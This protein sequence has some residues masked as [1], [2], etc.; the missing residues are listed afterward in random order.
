[1][2]QRT[3]ALNS[4]RLRTLLLGLSYPHQASYYDDWRNA[5]ETSPYFD[6]T[7]QNILNLRP[8]QLERQLSDYDAVVLLH[9]CSSDTLDYLTPLAPALAAR[10]RA[11]LF[12]FIGNEYNSPYVSMAKRIAF[13]REARADF[14]AT[15]LLLEAGDFLYKPAGCRVVSVPHALNPAAFQPGPA[16]ALR[17]VDIGFK[18]FRYPPYLGDDDRNHMLQAV[19]NCTRRFNLKTDISEDVR[20]NREDWAMFLG[21]CRA[22]ISTETGSWYLE[23]GDALMDEIHAYLRAKDRGL[24]L[25]SGGRLR[26]LA[27]RLPTSVKSV[28][29]K[30]LKKGPVKFEMFEDFNTSF[31]ELNERFFKNR[32]RTTVYSKA[33]SSRHFDAIGK[34]TCQIMLEGRYNDILVAGE[35]YIPVKADFSNIADAMRQ[36]QDQSL[37]EA[38]TKATYDYVMASHTYTHRA[39]QVHSLLTAT[40]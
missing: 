15:Q 20:F 26:R 14:A 37:T 27:R 17:R 34:T 24:T 28:L 3:P 9:S 5:F 39:R 31:E 16:Q 7:V 32:P 29:W 38:M 11:K 22:T 25:K 19:S 4:Q 40:A 10:V 36:F 6:C 12:S 33:I 30:V 21:D 2:T 13:L 18:G 8:K 1:M 35:H 23:P